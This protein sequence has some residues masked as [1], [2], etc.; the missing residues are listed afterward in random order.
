MKKLILALFL[1]IFVSPV[2]AAEPDHESTTARVLRTKTLRCAYTV[3]PPFLIK[4]PNTGAFSGFSYDFMEELGKQ[5]GLKIEWT[6]EVGTDSIFA[7]MGRRYDA[8]CLGYSATPS[9]IWGGDFSRPFV[10]VPYNMYVQADDTRFKSFDDLNAPDVTL[11]TADGEWSQIIAAEQFSKAKQLAMPGLTP[12]SDRME[13]VAAR[14]AQAA[15]MEALIGAEY[16]AKNPGKVK[17][18][19]TK[20]LRVVGSV[21]MIP[22][23]ESQLRRM[24]D[25]TIDS[26]LWSGAVDRLVAKYQEYPG[27]L[28][29]PEKGYEAE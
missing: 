25:V 29:A 11:A 24:L 26:M 2:F 7:G 15:S 23:G 12:A 14:K 1:L 6:E 4:D 8:S 19:G 22:H 16:M 20:P 17:R 10:F 3:Y 27:T 9:R 21:I 28:L 5:L 13:A 18:L